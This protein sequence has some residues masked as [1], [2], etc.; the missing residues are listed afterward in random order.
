MKITRAEIIN[1]CKTIV[2]YQKED[3]DNPI[4]K[5][6]EIKFKR[7]YKVD[8][9]DK[10]ATHKLIDGMLLELIDDPEITEAFNS[11]FKYYI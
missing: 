7:M 5:L 11:F 3:S 8:I 10:A 2:G 1:V 4:L 6:L 9:S